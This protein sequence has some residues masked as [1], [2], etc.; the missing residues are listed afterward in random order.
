MQR[1]LLVWLPLPP[2]MSFGCLLPL[3]APNLLL[4]LQLPL[5]TQLPLRSR[6]WLLPP[7]PLAIP[8]TDI[9]ACG[10]FLLQLL[11]FPLSCIQACGRLLI[12]LLS[13]RC[14]AR[15][16]LLLRRHRLLGVAV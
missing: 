14:H 10:G 4:P 9:A 11:R 3:F 1:L 5:S 12:Q 2:V 8:S 16:P 13:G 7:T 6:L 15:Q